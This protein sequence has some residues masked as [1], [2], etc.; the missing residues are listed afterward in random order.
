MAVGGKQLLAEIDSGTIELLRNECTSIVESIRLLTN[1][2]G[3]DQMRVELSD[4]RQLRMARIDHIIRARAHWETIAFKTALLSASQN[5]RVCWY[6]RGKFASA[7]ADRMVIE[8]NFEVNSPMVSS[9]RDTI[10]PWNRCSLSLALTNTEKTWE[11]SVHSSNRDLSRQKS[12]R[13]SGTSSNP[14]SVYIPDQS[15]GGNLISCQSHSTKS[16]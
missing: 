1:V 9:N 8:D 5:K 14:P 3:S 10:T 15:F 12:G 11:A 6:W 2:A 13:Q 4:W 16:A 7:D